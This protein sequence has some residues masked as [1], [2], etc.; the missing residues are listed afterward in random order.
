MAF[1]LNITYLIC[2]LSL[3]NLDEARSFLTHHRDRHKN[4]VPDHVLLPR[5]PHSHSTNN[6]LLSSPICD[7]KTYSDRTTRKPVGLYAIFAEYAWSKLRSSGLLNMTDEDHIT[8]DSTPQK[9]DSSFVRIHVVS[10]RPK[11]DMVIRYARYALLETIAT[12]SNSN[13]LS[14]LNGTQVL[15]FVIFPQPNIAISTPILGIDL[16]T[17]PGGKNLCAIDF[18]P[19][20]SCKC[21][22][23]YLKTWPDRYSSFEHR[24]QQLHAKFVK[25]RDLAWG[26]D[27]PDEASRFFSP[28]ALWTRFKSDQ[29]FKVLHEDIY[30]AF[31]AYVDL[32]IDLLL[33]IQSDLCHSTVN[34]YVH[35]T[36][37]KN[38]EQKTIQG[39]YDYLR[40]R[41]EHDPARPMLKRFY[42][43]EWT[44]TLIKTKLF[45]LEI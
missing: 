45:P 42:G 9:V 8:R 11:V 7:D 2:I 37:E 43:E 19:I 3:L 22:N 44:E 28:Y 16:V 18:Q 23:D 34:K 1:N 13:S 25:D 5:T 27:I 15:N 26:G 32:Y 21:Y 29:E 4:A 20:L 41:T 17:L 38:D 14:C 6:E 33:H 39:Q 40:Y 30:P 12:E 35:D 31:T 36:R 10:A 24:L